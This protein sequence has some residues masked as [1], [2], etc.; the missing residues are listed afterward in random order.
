[1]KE[2]LHHANT[3]ELYTGLLMLGSANICLVEW[4]CKYTVQLKNHTQW[5]LQFLS[6][7]L[8]FYYKIFRDCW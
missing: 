4:F 3:V 1:M 2:V 6:N 7:E 5:N 8:I